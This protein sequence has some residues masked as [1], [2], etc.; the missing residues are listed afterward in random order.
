MATDEALALD[1]ALRLAAVAV[2]RREAALLLAHVLGTDRR[3]LIAGAPERVPAEAARRLRRLVRQ[4]RRGQPLAYLT[5]RAGFWDMELAV[6]PGVLVPRPETELLVECA[7]DEAAAGA[8]VGT[9]VDVGTGSGALAIAIARALAGVEVYAS[10]RSAAALAI[11]R[12]NVE[13]WA[14]GVRLL[15]PGDLLEP[16]V[17]AGVRADVVVMNPPY[18][19]RRELARLPREVQCEPRQALDGGSDGLALVR[20]LVRA[21]GRGDGVRPGARVWI[22]VGAGQAEPAARILRSLGGPVRVRRDLAGIERAVG[23]RLRP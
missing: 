5:G 16:A 22:E 21:L 13:R 11:A 1:D 2:G 8:A 14:P 12:R 18:V 19:R 7:R 20:R 3:G 23:V 10:D 6:G 9:V 17:R 4:R 15:P